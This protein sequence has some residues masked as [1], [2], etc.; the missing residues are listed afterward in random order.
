MT[1]VKL[2]ETGDFSFLV[3]KNT[4]KWTKKYKQKLTYVHVLCE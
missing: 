4:Y 2:W 1:T 3:S